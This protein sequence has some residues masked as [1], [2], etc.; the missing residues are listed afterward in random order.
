MAS[1]G[2]LFANA[3]CQAPICGPSRVSLMSGL[4]PTTTGIYGQ[5]ND[6]KLRTA[7]P[8]MRDVPFLFEYFRDHGYK[9]MGVGKLFHQH[10]PTASA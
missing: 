3:H 2:T 4:Y 10:A 5:I 6:E 7:S 9:T 1:R 8:P